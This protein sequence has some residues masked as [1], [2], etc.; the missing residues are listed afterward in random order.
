MYT[1][2]DHEVHF[3]DSF[4]SEQIT[5]VLFF[6][7]PTLLYYFKILII[8]L[9]LFGAEISR[10]LKQCWVCVCSRAGTLLENVTQNVLKSHLQT[11]ENH[12]Q[13]FHPWNIMNVTPQC[14]TNL[15]SL[16]FN[17]QLP[18]WLRQ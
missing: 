13:L 16:P 10:E 8:I 6:S 1:E 18:R 7:Q 2:A 12:I 15:T 4:S 17:F 3:S 9:Q 14:N 11:A 5:S